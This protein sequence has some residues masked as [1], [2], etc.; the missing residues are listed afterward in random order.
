MGSDY[1]ESRVVVKLDLITIGKR[2]FPGES[3]AE[4]LG[5]WSKYFHFVCLR[6]WQVLK[7]SY[8]WQTERGLRCESGGGGSVSVPKTQP[9]GFSLRVLWGVPKCQE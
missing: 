3:E 9:L 2:L 6:T 5:G 1:S 8:T 7:D 4:G